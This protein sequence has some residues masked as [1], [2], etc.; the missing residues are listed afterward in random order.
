MKVRYSRDE[1][2][3]IIEFSDEKIDY[4]E[5]MGPIIVHFTED[6]KPVMLEI[7]DASEFIAEISKIA[8]RVKDEPIEV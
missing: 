7:L 8:M 4:A 5:E 3:L 1:D 6:G 2:I